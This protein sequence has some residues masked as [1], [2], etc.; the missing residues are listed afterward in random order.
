[1]TRERVE[2]LPGNDWRRRSERFQEPELSKNLEL[3]ERLKGIGER[4]GVSPGAVAV[5]WTLRNPAVDGA[6]TGFR[7]PDQVEPILAAADLELGDEEA[8]ALGG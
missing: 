5:A 7:R 4:H 3:V 2:S 1:M 6:I 8:A